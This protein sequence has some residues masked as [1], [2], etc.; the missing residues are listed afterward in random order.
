[1]SSILLKWGIFNALRLTEMVNI[2]YSNMFDHCNSGGRDPMCAAIS[3][4]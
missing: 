1:M 4:Q 3:R 2:Q